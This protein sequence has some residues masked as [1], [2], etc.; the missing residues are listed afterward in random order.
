MIQARGDFRNLRASASMAPFRALARGEGTNSARLFTPGKRKTLRS[1]HYNI[2][3]E[4]APIFPSVK[5][6][7]PKKWLILVLADAYLHD[8]WSTILMRITTDQARFLSPLL[9][10]TLVMGVV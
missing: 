2:T 1:L 5:Q 9:F 8:N 7:N 6:V 4:P 10:S 3:G